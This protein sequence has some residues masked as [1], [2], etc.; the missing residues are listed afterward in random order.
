MEVVSG[1]CNSQLTAKLRANEIDLA[2]GAA[3]PS[4]DLLSEELCADEM[5]CVT[6]TDFE[7]RNHWYVVSDDLQGLPNMISYGD[8]GEE[9]LPVA[10][11]MGITAS[12]SFTSVD[13]TSLV[14]L[15]ESEL[16]FNAPMG[17][18]KPT[19]F[20]VGSIPLNRPLTRSFSVH[21]VQIFSVLLSSPSKTAPQ[22]NPRLNFLHP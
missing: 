5:L 3:S 8:Y 22:L 4:P 20:D 15:A 10:Q 6:S 19:I 9:A 16:G 14:A 17:R 12:S 13:D 7:L 18:S 1:F 11:H 21:N 2:I